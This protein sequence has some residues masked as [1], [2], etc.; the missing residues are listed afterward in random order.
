MAGRFIN[1]NRQGKITQG[2][3][4]NSINTAVQ[5]ILNNPYYLYSDKR[6][7]ECTYFNINT[8]MTTLDEA[9]RGN[10]GEISP[11]SPFRYNQIDG[12][13][14]Y[15]LNRLDINLEVGEFGLESSEITDDG[16]VLPYTIVPYPG[17]FFMINNIKGPLMF[18]VIGVNPNTLDTG[19]TMYKI[20]YTLCTSDGLEDITP[21]VVRRY[22]FMI[23]NIG[24]N[25]ATFMDEESYSTA[26]DLEAYSTML[27]NYYISLF[28][29]NKIQ[30]FSY[31]YRDNGTIGGAMTNPYGYHEFNGFKVYD[32]YLT[33]F[34]IRNK[35]IVG[36]DEYIYLTQAMYM[37]ATFPI[38]Y[39]KTFFSSLEEC[40]ISKHNGKYVGNLLLCDQ[41]LSLLYQYPIDYYFMEYSNNLKG[42]FLINIFDDDFSIR[43]KENRKYQEDE[44]KGLR[45]IL[46]NY[47][48]GQ[49]T[50]MDDLKDLKHIDYVPNKELF[51][52]IPMVIF[53]IDKSIAGIV[54]KNRDTKDI[55]GGNNETK[56]NLQNTYGKLAITRDG[57]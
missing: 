13:F 7:T 5:N 19:A 8:T 9:T 35:I 23:Q 11:E 50:T 34:I 42:L 26:G 10:F 20:N 39:S 1:T 41:K 4:S 53:C 27:K 44:Y 33:E 16:F 24:T 6:G 29:D 52:L 40:D 17:D 51:Y 45:N 55:I 56:R 49:T 2:A 54:S 25:F 37:P 57:G 46:I 30:G 36:S 15:G 14:L 3:I 21:Q 43:I 31:E 18:K 48:N 32:A 22:K 12:F 47:F 38:E 28:F